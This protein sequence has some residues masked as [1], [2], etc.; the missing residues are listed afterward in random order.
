MGSDRKSHSIYLLAEHLL[1]QVDEEGNQYQ[2]F[3]DIIDHC[4]H[5]K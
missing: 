3:E 1:L 5:P 2:I 4:K